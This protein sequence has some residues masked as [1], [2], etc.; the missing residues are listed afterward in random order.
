MFKIEICGH[1][2]HMEQQLRTE[3][4]LQAFYSEVQTQR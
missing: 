2:S 1:H 4:Q 3:F